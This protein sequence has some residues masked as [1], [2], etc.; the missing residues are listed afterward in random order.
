[1]NL[2]LC[3]A[4]A[5]IF[6]V[7]QTA[8]ASE[9]PLQ[10]SEAEVIKAIAATEQ[11]DVDMIEMLAWAK[12]GLVKSLA[13]HGISTDSLKAG[14]IAFKQRPAVQLG[15]L[16]NKDGRVLALSGN[17][18]WLR[19]SSLRSLKKLTELRIIRIDH[20]G[21]VGRDPQIPEFDGSGFAALADSK[22]VE[23]KIGLSF[24]DRGMEQCARIKSLKSFTV[25]HSRVTEAG[26]AF[27]A[28]HPNLTEFSIA[29]M[30]PNP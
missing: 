5:V 3:L 24:S 20:N 26:I 25:G 30:A 8:R 19:N 18:P 10:P 9:L 12:N 13:D 7:Q 14:V 15:Y 28:G 4:P 27:F 2:H 22:L 1:M 21:F 17:G 29:E 11:L 6:G 23:I 16:Y